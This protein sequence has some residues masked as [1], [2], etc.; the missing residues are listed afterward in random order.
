MFTPSQDTWSLSTDRYLICYAIK[1]NI[2]PVF[3][4][5]IL[6]EYGIECTL[7]EKSGEVLS[8]ERIDCISPDY[9]KVFKLTQILKKFE[10]F[11][12]HLKDIVSDLLLLTNEEQSQLLCIG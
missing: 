9:D 4:D 8:F 10:V 7:T 6:Y 11:P 3:S 12:A 1:K 5:D 2:N